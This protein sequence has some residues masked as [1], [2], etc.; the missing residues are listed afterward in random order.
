[1]IK[2]T[3]II[4]VITLIVSLFPY[5]VIS[6]ENY[7][8]ISIDAWPDVGKILESPLYTYLMIDLNSGK[9]ISK[10]ISNASLI[11]TK[12]PKSDYVI[13]LSITGKLKGSKKTMM[14]IG[15]T[16]IHLSDRRSIMI[17]VINMNEYKTEKVAVRIIEEKRGLPV[18]LAIKAYYLFPLKGI[19]KSNK[20][21]LNSTIENNGITILT[22]LKV[23][24]YILVMNT[25]NSSNMFIKNSHNIIA[26]ALWLPGMKTLTIDLKKHTNPEPFRIEVTPIILTTTSARTHTVTKV[27][28]V[29]QKP[30][31]QE[32]LGSSLEKETLKMTTTTFYDYYVDTN[33][34]YKLLIAITIASIVSLTMYIYIV[35]LRRR[36]Y[37]S[38]YN[39]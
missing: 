2:R 37:I 3:T 23:P 39:N 30:S 8:E 28:I 11:T 13:I 29:S 7:V 22:L 12:L 32:L 26:S 36:A 34:F 27:I 4:L 17:R 14:F 35:I 16:I 15:Y 18:R 31:T 6:T 24:C 10:I 19:L 38:D 25:D 9:P 20:L 1:M 5:I 21:K 33:D